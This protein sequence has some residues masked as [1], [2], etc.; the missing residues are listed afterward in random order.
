FFAVDTDPMDWLDNFERAKQVN[1]WNDDVA[2]NMATIFVHDT[3]KTLLLEGEKPATDLAT[4]KT[5]FEMLYQTHE[6]KTRHYNKAHNYC[7]ADNET[8]DQFIAT[9]LRLFKKANI[10]D[11]TTKCR[12]FMSAANDHIHDGLL[13]KNPSTFS[14]MVA[15][16]QNE[17][18]ISQA[19]SERRNHRPAQTVKGSMLTPLPAA[20][21]SASPVSTAMKM[22]AVYPYMPPPVAP[23]APAASVVD[24][25]ISKFGNLSIN[26]ANAVMGVLGARWAGRNPAPMPP[27]SRSDPRPPVECYRCR[28]PGHIA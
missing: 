15:V 25:I 19:K 2:Y 5:K 16:A 11:E 21:T 18:H 4:F 8:A 23:Q 7:Q 17:G 3:C 28:Q 22:P 9:M 20:V 27:N 6:Y 14:A 12:L 13:R 26:D 1:G 24:D 10:T